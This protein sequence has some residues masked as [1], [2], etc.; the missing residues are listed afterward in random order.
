MCV[1]LGV[2]SMLRAVVG[3]GHVLFFLHVPL[4]VVLREFLYQ[5]YLRKDKL[6]KENYKSK[7]AETKHKIN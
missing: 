1:H 2:A 4:L 5:T 7:V 6:I 3:L